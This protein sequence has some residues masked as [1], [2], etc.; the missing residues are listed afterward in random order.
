M[1]LWALN[2]VI[3]EHHT[4]AVVTVVSPGAEVAGRLTLVLLEPPT[5]TDNRGC[6]VFWTVV[7]HTTQTWV[8]CHFSL[9]AVIASAAVAYRK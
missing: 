5:G 4:I 1:A 6:R 9:W 2:G 7:T 3:D 8:V